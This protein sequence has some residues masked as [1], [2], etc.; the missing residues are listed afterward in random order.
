[1]KA[2]SAAHLEKASLAPMKART[3]ITVGYGDEAGRF[4]YLAAFHA[5]QAFTLER[6]GQ[7][8]KTHSG[9]H[10]QFGK[11]A[12][13]DPNFDLPLRQFLSRA[14][15]MKVAADYDLSVETAVPLD[16][17]QAAIDEGARFVDCVVSIINATEMPS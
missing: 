2:E 13:D 17:A 6:S 16:R 4:A 14:Y 11:L 1:M 15:E 10:S 12:K 9:V 5:A 7:V 3:M 8:S